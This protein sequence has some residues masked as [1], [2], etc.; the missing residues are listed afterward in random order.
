MSDFDKLRFE[1]ELMPNPNYQP[2]ASWRER[3]EAAEERAQQAE[4]ALQ[5][6][7]TIN[8]EPQTW[9]QM[10]EREHAERLRL[11]AYRSLLSDL[12]RCEHGRHE[13]DV[14]SGCHGDSHGNPHLEHGQVLGYSLGA[15]P[16][17]VP[18]GRGF[19][20]IDKWGATP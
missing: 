18:E 6:T 4:A 8:G 16:Y 7:W 5:S 19:Y 9:Q 15:K 17:I 2:Q 20:D 13:G 14:C 1:R 3:A 10:Y 11:D 12:D